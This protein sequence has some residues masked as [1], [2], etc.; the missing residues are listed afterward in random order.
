MKV[1]L[2]RIVCTTDFSDLSYIALPYAVSLAREFK[3]EL[4]IVH[5]VDLTTAAMYGEAVLDHDLILEST[6]KQAAQQLKGLI[7]DQPLDWETIVSLGKPAELVRSICL[8]KNVDLVISATRGRSGIKRVILGSVTERLMHTLPCPLLAVH[9]RTCQSRE[10]R[11]FRRILVG[12]DFS[13]DS[14]LAVEYGLNLAQELE[15]ELHLVH[16][17]EYDLLKETAESGRDQE[18]RQTITDT[19][20][21]DLDALVSEEARIWCNPITTLLAG[22]VA[23]E[24][25][26]YAVINKIDLIVLGVHGRDFIDSLLVGSTTDR[27]TRIGPCPVLAVRPMDSEDEA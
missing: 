12:C 18:H 27:I 11:L 3:A 13:P 24:I 19:L 14:D 22:K 21:S 16:V 5:A 6:Q 8:E 10:E 26:K 2:K 20:K 7:K 17:A 9:E 15:S 23:D 4:Y 25:K 1:D